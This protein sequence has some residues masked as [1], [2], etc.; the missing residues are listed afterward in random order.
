MDCVDPNPAEGITLSTVSFPELRPASLGLDIDGGALSLSEGRVQWVMVEQES[1]A[2]LLTQQFIQR[3]DSS[4]LA[5]AICSDARQKNLVAKL[6]DVSGPSEL[7]CL[8]LSLRHFSNF[9]KRPCSELDRA[10]NMRGRCIL[11]A[12]PSVAWEAFGER[13][14]ITW[15]DKMRAWLL[16][17][18]AT[19]L[20]VSEGIC[21]TVSD[22]LSRLT[23]SLSGFASLSRTAVGP[24]LFL[25]FWNASRGLI[26]SREYHLVFQS[27]GLRMAASSEIDP[28]IEYPDQGR[29]HAERSVLEGAQSLPAQ[30]RIF[31]G[32]SELFQHALASRAASV[33]FAITR[34][35]QVEDLAHQLNQLRRTCGN[36]LKLIVRETSPCL[37]YRD[38]QLLL[39]GGASLVVPF[40]TSLPR[41]LT[42]VESVQGHVWQRQLKDIEAN[43]DELKP[44][45]LRGQQSP[46]GF[47]EAVLEM[48]PSSASGEIIHQLIRLQPVPGLSLEQV[49]SQTRLRRNGDIACIAD[50]ALHLFLF[51]CRAESLEAALGN[52]FGVKWQELFV[53]LEQL[54]DLDFLSRPDFQSDASPVVGC[55]PVDEGKAAKPRQPLSPRPLRLSLEA[56]S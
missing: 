51:A 11:L 52:I 46:L 43:L 9:L 16:D 5:V 20:I 23:H 41:F 32:R 47:A 12:I 37:R 14:L 42:L 10:G 30:W 7:R 55:T 54:T 49:L 18:S 24:R 13:A 38:E 35:D 26:S 17:R 22:R 44:L 33:L 6:D 50:Q 48:W 29:V 31:E 56:L 3:L 21:D 8:A 19:L 2:A 40:G 27:G 15:L 4:Q 28:G 39:T 34:N 1:D 25:H 36:Q 45:P 53:G